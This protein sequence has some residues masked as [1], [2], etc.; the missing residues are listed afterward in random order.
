MFQDFIIGLGLYYMFG[1]DS[2][3]FMMEINVLMGKNVVVLFMD[4]ILKVGKNGC[5]GVEEMYEN[6][7]F[8][9]FW[10]GLGSLEKDMKDLQIYVVGK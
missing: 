2:F 8:D 1:M 7:L 6:I 3:I 5:K 9:Q 10:S 4:D